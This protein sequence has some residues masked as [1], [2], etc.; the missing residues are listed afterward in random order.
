MNIVDAIFLGCGVYMLYHT[1][2]MRTKGIIPE[3][4]LIN[5][6]QPL[7]KDA[8]IAGFILDMFWKSVV[9]GIGTCLSGIL[10]LV[11]AKVPAL[12]GIATGSLFVLFAIWV[13]FVVFLKKAHRKFLHIK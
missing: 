11:S 4:I 13:V 10:G 5:K 12:G 2:I 8:D 6:D 1:Y 3:G 9:V 7:P